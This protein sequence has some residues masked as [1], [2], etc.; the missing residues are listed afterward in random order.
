MQVTHLTMRQVLDEVVV[1]AT[2]LSGPPFSAPLHQF[3]RPG[4][5]LVQQ[6]QVQDLKM[7]LHLEYHDRI[8][9]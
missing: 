8:K 1:V 5:D 6:Q 2:P 9:E 3:S 7:Q 4:K